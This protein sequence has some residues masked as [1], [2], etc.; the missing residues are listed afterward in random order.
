MKQ[1]E[2]ELREMMSQG[3]QIALIPLISIVAL[4]RELGFNALADS[5][6]SALTVH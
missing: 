1:D 2:R 5:L 6:E 3:Y 4:A